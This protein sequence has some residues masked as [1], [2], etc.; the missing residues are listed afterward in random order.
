[1][2]EIFFDRGLSLCSKNH[3]QTT[4]IKKQKEAAMSAEYAEG[5]FTPDGSKKKVVGVV[6]AGEWVAS[7]K[8]VKS[9]VARPLL[10]ALE[11]AQKRNVIGTLQLPV[12]QVRGYGLEV[13]EVR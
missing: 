13:R 6:H 11:V 12:Q 3:L 4:V 8:L 10:E 2:K 5:R 9:P 1:M 7:Q